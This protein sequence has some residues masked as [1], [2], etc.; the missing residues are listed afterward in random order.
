MDKRYRI[1]QNSRALRSEVNA[2]DRQPAPHEH[3]TARLPPAKATAFQRACRAS[4]P[5]L[6]RTEKL[7]S[8]D[9]RSANRSLQA[10][11]DQS[12]LGSRYPPPPRRLRRT[13]PFRLRFPLFSYTTMKDI[14]ASPPPPFARLHI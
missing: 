6:P 11:P 8:K 12:A 2:R 1:W 7:P 4:P 9:R 10:N 3:D 14:S 13:T 5:T